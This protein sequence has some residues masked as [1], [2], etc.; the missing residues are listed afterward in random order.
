MP[1]IS[2]S[3][4]NFAEADGP[5][6]VLAV[7]GCGL[8]EGI[9]AAIDVPGVIEVPGAIDIPGDIAGLAAAG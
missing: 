3:Q 1:L 8:R 5:A 4:I 6:A 7:T 2:D 9:G